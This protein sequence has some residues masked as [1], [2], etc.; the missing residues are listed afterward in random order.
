MLSP[1]PSLLPV[2][3]LIALGALLQGTAHAA[4]ADQLPDIQH[5]V[6]A[7]DTL[8]AVAKRY[9]KDPQQWRELGEANAIQQPKHLPV[10]SVIV[11]PARLV[12]YQN[13]TVAH[14]QGTA[15]TR[16]PQTGSAW[17]PLTKGATL[18]EGDE[19]QVPAGSFVTGASADGSTVRVNEKSDL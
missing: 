12:G 17:Q 4:S 19:L 5:T 10:G 6:Q 13:V 8:E 16:S 2:S 18:T 15:Q 7:G 9:L 11:I 1:S 14:V 3:V